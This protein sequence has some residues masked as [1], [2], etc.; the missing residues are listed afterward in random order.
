MSAPEVIA[1]DA[2]DGLLDWAT[3]TSAIEAGHILPQAKIGD[4]LLRRDGDTLLSRAAFIDGLGALVKS[5]TVFPGNTDLPSVNGAACLFSDR[6]GQL[7]A[8]IDFHLLTKW[9]T[10][11]DSLLAA[12]RLAPPRVAR[13]LIVGAGTVA[14]TLVSAYRSV[15]PG[16]EIA[17]WNRTPARAERLAARCAISVAR[18]L[19]AAVGAADLIGCATMSASPV[20]AGAWLRPGQHLDLIGAYRPDMREADDTCLRRGRLF[21][22]SRATTMA[23]IG[24]LAIPL[25]EGVIAGEDVLADFYEPARFRRGADDI[26][27][28]K[29]GGGAHL[30]LMVARAILERWRAARSV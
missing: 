19:E 21:V 29:N 3:I 4:T 23:D 14:E 26:T 6:D 30:D 1:F 2:A 9:K 18:D 25:R 22:D 17:V 16:A 27:V 10:A 15:W 24:E 5:A 20:I 12:M 11:G 7:E 13:I 8:L 28:F